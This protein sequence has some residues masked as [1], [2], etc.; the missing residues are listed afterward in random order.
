MRV[1]MRPSSSSTSGGELVAAGPQDP[2]HADELADPHQRPGEELGIAVVDLAVL[3]R[4]AQAGDVAAREPLVVELQH[5]RRDELG[6][7]DDPVERRMLRGEA[8]ERGEAE[9]LHLGARRALRRGLR[10][11][12]AHA[13]VQVDDELVEDLLLAREV[14][15]EG[16]L[17]DARPPR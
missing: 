4:L 7:A 5:L 17:P 14:E 2:A 1:T 16:A 15:V 10:H 9:P 11:R 12:L 13:V 6:L 8:E 3:H